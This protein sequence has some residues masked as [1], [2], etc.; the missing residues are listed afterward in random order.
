MEKLNQEEIKQEEIKQEEIKQKK[1]R[2]PSAQK[3]SPAKKTEKEDCNICAETMAKSKFVA[4]PYCSFECCKKCVET[5]LLSLDDDNPRCMNTT[6]KKVWSLT[7]VANNFTQSF[8]KKT[9]RDRRTTILLDR[10]KSMLPEAQGIIEIENKVKVILDKIDKN[11]ELA[12]RLKNEKKRLKLSNQSTDRLTTRIKEIKLTIDEL[13][14]EYDVLNDN[15]IPKQV[16]TVNMKCPVDAC[17]GFVN[18]DYVCGLCNVFV[19]K[20]CRIVVAEE[21]KKTHVCDK[22]LV[23]TVKLLAKD[24]KNCPSCATPIFKIDGCDQMYCTLCHTAFSWTKGEIEKGVIHNPHFYQYM[25]ENGLDANAHNNRNRNNQNMNP[26]DNI[27]RWSVVHD[28]LKRVKSNKSIIDLM[29]NAHRMVGHLNY[30]LTVNIVPNYLESRL[31]FLRGEIDEPAW[32]ELI[33]RK[34]KKF[35]KDTEVNMVLQMVSNTFKDFFVEFISLCFTATGAE[36]IMIGYDVPNIHIL[37]NSVITK[38]I[39][40]LEDKI[41]NICIYANDAL[42]IINKHYNNI[43]PYFDRNAEFYTSVEYCPDYLRF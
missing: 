22:D 36:F 34:Q 35:E 32:K 31:N 1:P 18:N 33:K 19:C 40:D 42:K 16:K 30:M 4:C 43:V 5:F 37:S 15:A 6:C 14:E 7:F 25:R 39:K 8:Y 21:D 17:R 12:K 29:C 26:C 28:C 13:Y 2:K 27:P 23:A 9:Y 11:K 41:T 38:N 3:K 10:E 20:H 24:T